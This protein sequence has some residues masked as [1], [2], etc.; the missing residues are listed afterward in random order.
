[1]R[2]CLAHRRINLSSNSRRDFD[3]RR[4][5]SSKRGYGRRWEKLRKMIL[6]RDPLCCVRA[7]MLEL[8]VM[9]RHAS[10]VRNSDMSV[11]TLLELH[12]KHFCNGTRPSTDVDH[13]IPRPAGDDNEDNLQGACHECHSYKTAV[14]DSK[15]ISRGRGIDIST[16]LSLA[17]RPRPKRHT[18]AK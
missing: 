17:D 12:L 10:M 2:Y 16:I 5:S 6:A 14:F 18:P 13:I 4:G 15:F 9:A 1:M 7:N 3:Q 8:I 11:L